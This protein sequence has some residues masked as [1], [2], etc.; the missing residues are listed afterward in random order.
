MS[1][2]LA[3]SAQPKRWGREVETVFFN[4]HSCLTY[5]DRPRSLAELLTDSL[6]WQEQV[7]LIEGQR[8][9]TFEGHARAVAVVATQLRSAGVRQ[10]DHVMLLG[11][12]RVE[13]LLAFW[14][15][16]QLGAVA[17]LGN[18][19]WSDAETK[20]AVDL[21]RPVLII[22]DRASD[23]VRSLGCKAIAFNA[24]QTDHG[25]D[26]FFNIPGITVAEDD[27]ALLMFSSGTTGAAKAVVMSHRAVIANIQNLLALTGRLPDEIE[28]NHVATTSLLTV[29]LFHL[30]GIQISFLTL[31]SGGALVFL[32]GKF[33]PEKVLRLIE[34]ERVR[35]WGGIPTMVSRVI[36]YEHFGDFDTTSLKSI[37]MG[38]AAVSPELRD[39]IGQAFPQIRK[40]VG[41]LYGL[42]EA[43][44]VLAASSGRDLEGKP[45]CVGRPLPVV[46]IRIHNADA[47]GVGEI[48]ARTPSA[49][50]H[51]LGDSDSI[52][53]AEGWVKTGDLGR[54]DEDGLLYV[55][56]R[57]KDIIIRGGE[58]IASVHVE[59]SLAKHPDV[60]EVAV[61]ALPHDDLGEEVAAAVVLRSGAVIR[62]QELAAFAEGHLGR[63]EIP[64]RWW[65]RYTALPT[66]ATGKI[67]KRE[68]VAEWPVD[69]IRVDEP[70]IES[71][72]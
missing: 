6:R 3:V 2:S 23:R 13:W 50:S 43:G 34:Q 66:N 5:R 25:A 59:R 35:V 7:F 45:G 1:E 42:T 37:P 14:A 70:N 53:D 68:L 17:A 8:R 28:P 19:W 51:Y 47:N 54:L 39:K 44:G 62:A 72:P 18:A 63:F 4:K 60:L 71:A 57:S 41:S 55:V 64:S 10:G 40:S 31:L 9:F 29:P 69:V 52:T 20:H 58:N 46:E 24:L 48:W 36:E 65:L 22:T 26:T 32:E 61:V 12:N 11:F 56:G 38:G 30:S 21:V 27:A 67:L 49:A 15:I 33:S 16:Q